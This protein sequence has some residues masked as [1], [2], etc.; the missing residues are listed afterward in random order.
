MVRKWAAFALAWSVRWQWG[1]LSR[2]RRKGCKVTIDKEQLFSRAYDARGF[3][4]WLRLRC[5][6]E[7]EVERENWSAQWSIL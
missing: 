7:G 2:G 5:G 6:G 4:C 1:I 3:T